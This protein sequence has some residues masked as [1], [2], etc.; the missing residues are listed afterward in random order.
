MMKR[1]RGKTYDAY[2][3]YTDGNTVRK[4]DEQPEY[5]KQQKRD[6]QQM[7]DRNVQRLHANSKAMPWTSFFG[8]V[9]AVA[10]VSFFCMSYLR[11]ESAL[12][13]SMKTI[14][15]ME[16]DLEKL[17]SENDAKEASIHA[18]IDLDEI[19]QTATGRLG[20]VYANESQVIKYDKTESEY[21]RQYE[22]IPNQ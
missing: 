6:V 7:K 15:N 16:K 21:V 13:K 5:R 10:A 4:I 18:S 9:L 8:L 2:R 12:Q 20:M 19:F 22:D 11:A 14:E 3:A 1:T 17:K